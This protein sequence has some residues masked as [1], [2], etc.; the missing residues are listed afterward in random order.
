MSKFLS[1]RVC[2]ILGYGAET[3]FAVP[4][5]S[6]SPQQLIMALGFLYLS[7]PGMDMSERTTNRMIAVFLT[8]RVLPLVLDKGMQVNLSSIGAL[9]QVPKRFS[10]SAGRQRKRDDQF[11]HMSQRRKN[12]TAGSTSEV[13]LLR[14]AQQSRVFFA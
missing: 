6:E 10:R 1:A 8:G 4:D 14:L 12:S 2:N 7:T 3:P 9:S 13:V 11:Q 5:V